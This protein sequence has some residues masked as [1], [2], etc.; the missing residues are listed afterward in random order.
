MEED[1]LGLCSFRALVNGRLFVTTLVLRPR[2]CYWFSG[3]VS[4]TPSD[5]C[6]FPDGSIWTA[7]ALSLAAVRDLPPVPPSDE[8]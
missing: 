3:V 5:G 6:G 7:K 4:G 1:P 2:S 8:G